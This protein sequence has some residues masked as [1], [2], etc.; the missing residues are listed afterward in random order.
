M[1]LTT[2]ILPREKFFVRLNVQYDVMRREL[3]RYVREGIPDYVLVSWNELP[4]EFTNYQ[5]IAVDTGYDDDNRLNKALYLY[6][7]I[8][9]AG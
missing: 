1:Y 9:Q 2:G 4:A 7:R 3:D 8:Q 6:R 5:L